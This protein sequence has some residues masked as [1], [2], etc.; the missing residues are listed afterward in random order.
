MLPPAPPASSEAVRRVL[1]RNGR[2]DT[3]PEQSLRRE[4]REDLA[5]MLRTL[6]T[7]KRREKKETRNKKEVSFL[8]QRTEP[9]ER[10]N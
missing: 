2:R 10:T 7:D 5:E 4:L 1:Q 3:T 6:A 9:R 8:N